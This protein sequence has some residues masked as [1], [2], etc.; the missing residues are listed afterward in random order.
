[1]SIFRSKVIAEVNAFFV[2]DLH[3]LSVLLAVS[4]VLLF[5]IFGTCLES[6]KCICFD[7]SF[8]SSGIHFVFN[9]QM[10]SQFVFGSEGYVASCFADL[11]WTDVMRL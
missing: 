5:F 9:V 4:V 3:N 7:G 2:Q 6:K 1:M 10:S 8:G 11:V